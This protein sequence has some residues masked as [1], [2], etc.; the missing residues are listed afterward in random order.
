MSKGS[1]KTSQLRIST[2]NAWSR[3][4]FR[5]ALFG[6]AAFLL[7]V[8]MMFGLRHIYPPNGDM[9]VL[10][11][12]W[13]AYIADH[14]FTGIATI[15]QATGSD[16]TPIW[17]FLMFLFVQTKFYNPQTVEYC[18]KALA[19]FGTLVATVATYFIVKMLVKRPGSWLPLVAAIIVPFLPAFFMDTVKTNIP[20][21]IYLGL[22]LLALLAFFKKR[23][24][25][26]W[27]LV[28]IA[29]SFKMMAIYIIPFF[30]FL[31]IRGWSSGKIWHRV[32]PLFII[33]GFLVTC[34]PGYLAGLNL[35]DSTIGVLVFRATTMNYEWWGIWQLLFDNTLLQVPGGIP[36]DQVHNVT[37]YG[38]AMLLLIFVVLFA[39]LFG[40]RDIHRQN[41]AALDFLLASP[42]L[43]Y[44]FLPS[45]HESY[46][47][48]SS[49]C[50]LIVLVIRRSRSSLAV[51][52]ILSFT[53]FELFV[54]GRVVS[55][56]V[57]DYVLVAVAG[58]LCFRI[59]QASDLRARWRGE[60]AEAT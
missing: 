29:L 17:H 44:L 38:L 5:Q 43:C 24:G 15:R 21:S 4:G 41:Q 11:R 14:G 50:A 22:D 45:Q 18:V 51:L 56:I 25:L 52:L 10:L 31:W 47:A 39:L 7:W 35:F 40:I 26:A 58:Y 16:I 27:F 20:D 30:V 59:F 57:L 1:K 12:P 55:I 46:W 19:I 54:G 42:I 53:L 36:A 34:I 37:L 13:F 48:L 3:I 23:P 60:I 2:A 33:P 9:V 6:V 28:G 32:S 8:V 49:V